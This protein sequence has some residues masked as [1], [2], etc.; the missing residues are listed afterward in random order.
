MV[1]EPV[2]DW[3][4]DWDHSDPAWR[5][6]LLDLGRP[7]RALPGRRT[8]RYGGAVMVTTWDLIDAV[9][10]DPTTFSSRETGVRPPGTN[11]KKS[12]PI[13]SDP[14]EHQEHRRIL[15]PSFSPQSIAALEDGLRDYC[16][17]LLHV[18]QGGEPSTPPTS[19]PDTSRPMPSPRCSGCRRKMPTRSARG[20]RPS[21]SRATSTR[22]RVSERRPS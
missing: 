11:T 20:S 7:P 17:G 1:F 15:L 12:P 18:L 8:E 6:T 16:R 13:T 10:H 3:R 9:T 19:T 4:T 2:E 5:P 14:P 22:R 21:W